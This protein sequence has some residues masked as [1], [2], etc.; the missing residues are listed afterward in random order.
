MR[1]TSCDQFIDIV[2]HEYFGSMAAVTPVRILPLLTDDAVLTGFAHFVDLE[3]QR[4]AC[5]FF[6]EI[7]PLDHGLQPG[8]RLRN[9]NFFRFEGGLIRAVTA[10]FSEPPEDVDPWH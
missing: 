8:R 1:L 7:T 3:Q 4:C 6:L 10:Y 9:C 5:T 2:E